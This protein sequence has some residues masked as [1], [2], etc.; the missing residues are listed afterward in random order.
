[1]T[2]KKLWTAAKRRAY[3]Y[4]TSLK[5]KKHFNPYR[6]GLEDLLVDIVG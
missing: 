2:Y 5:K 4:C 3:Q 6:D 1:M